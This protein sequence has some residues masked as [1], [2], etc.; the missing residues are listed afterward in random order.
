MIGAQCPLSI[1]YQI[2]PNYR[3]TGRPIS[4]TPTGRPISRGSYKNYGSLCFS[5]FLNEVDIN[6]NFYHIQVFN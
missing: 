4:T 6:M 1:K 5:M 3:P 2:Q